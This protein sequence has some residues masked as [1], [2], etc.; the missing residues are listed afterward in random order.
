MDPRRR[1][2][3]CNRNIL[4]LLKLGSSGQDRL[5][6]KSWP[7]YFGGSGWH[8]ACGLFEPGQPADCDR[9]TQLLRKL[10]SDIRTSDRTLTSRTSPIVT[11]TRVFIQPTGENFAKLVWT[12]IPHP[13]YSTD[14]ASSDFHLFGLLKD[15]LRGQYLTNNGELET[16]VSLSSKNVDKELYRAG[17]Q[18][19]ARRWE[20]C[21][22]VNGNWEER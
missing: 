10:K 9:F 14:L 17:F 13:S 19:C 18:Q 5:R 15:F 20:K 21:V 7:L 12:V 3:H 1:G 16:T 6:G 22:L 2:S 11:T 4:S 8:P